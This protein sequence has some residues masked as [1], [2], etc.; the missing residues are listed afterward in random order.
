MKKMSF[1]LVSATLIFSACEE[2]DPREPGLLVPRTVEE[3]ISLPSIAVNGTLLHSE[4]FGN[5]A[6]PMV[7]V[8]HGGPGSDYRYIL[9]CRDLAGEG[10]YVIFYDQRGSGLSKREPKSSYTL[11]VMQDDLSGVIAHYRTSVDQKLILLGQSWG[12]ILA[13]AYINQNPAAIDGLILS[14][15]GGFTWSDIKD[16][17]KRSRQ[18]GIT[19]EA[20]NDVTYVDQFLT[21]KESDHAVLDYKMSLANAAGSGEGN[22]LGV[23]NTVPF[24]RFGYVVNQAL[25]ELGEREQPDWTQNLGSYETK[26]LFLYSELNQAYGEAHASHVS[27]AY[28]NVQLELIEGAGHDLITSPVGWSQIFPLALNYLNEIK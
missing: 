3:D 4:A 26:V 17:V 13:T 7:V 23:A 12:A 21:G 24:W 8:V 25:F 11:Q 9:N 18:Y 14:E 27:S 16:Y 5:P 19:S 1:L 6:D 20:L 15:P 10:F 28:S 22:P 2:L